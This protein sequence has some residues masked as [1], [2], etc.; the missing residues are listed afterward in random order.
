[1]TQQLTHDLKRIQHFGL[2]DFEELK[3]LINEADYDASVTE[4]GKATKKKWYH[5]THDAF[6]RLMYEVQ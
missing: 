5:M 6:L 4:W 3:G 2:L 1:M